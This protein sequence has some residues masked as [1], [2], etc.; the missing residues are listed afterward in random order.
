MLR[1]QRLLSDGERALVEWFGLR[2]L[3]SIVIE[4]CPVIEAGGDVGMLRPE[5][6]LPDSQRALI[7]RFCLGA[8]SLIVIEQRQV[9]LS[10]SV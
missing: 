3:A 5:G 10:F 7:E 4:L 6:L 1:P 8:S 2:I 9:V